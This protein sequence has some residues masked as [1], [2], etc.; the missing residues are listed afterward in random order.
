MNISKSLKDCCD[1]ALTR[2]MKR[3]KN[4]S[5]L[6]EANLEAD[7]KTMTHLITTNWQFDISSQAATNLQTKKWNKV[8]I[9]PLASDLKILK[10]YLLKE[11]KL[12][13]ENLSNS[14]TDKKAYV[15]LVELIFTQVLLLNRKRP[16]ELERLQIETYKGAGT[17]SNYEEFNDVI[18]LSEKVLMRRFKRI[19]I[20]EKRGRGVPVLFSDIVQQQIELVLKVRPYFFKDVD[21]IYLFGIPGHTTPMAGYKI[22]EKYAKK[23]GTKN[24]QAITATKLRKHLATITQLM[25]MTDT[26]VEQLATFMGHTERVHRNEYRLPDDVYQ[27]ARMCKLL[28]IME[29]GQGAAYK[30]KRLDEV[31]LDMEEN[32]L[33]GPS[34]NED[35]EIEDDPDPIP[36]TSTTS[37]PVKSQQ[38][39]TKKPRQLVPWTNEQKKRH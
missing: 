2:V 6:E 3:K 35:S 34:E 4:H 38:S 23:S 29:S 26:D 9:I 31:E 28:S 5:T 36:S 1:I 16:G 27:T 15:N 33:E 39:T 13:M 19:V 32:I 37:E 8:T 14:P 25:N 30:G 21:N 18:T 17:H 24:P 7:I 10:D 20:R 12:A 11:S 22:I